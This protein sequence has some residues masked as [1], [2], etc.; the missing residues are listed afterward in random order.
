LEAP[1]YRVSLHSK[2]LSKLSSLLPES[3]PR[4]GHGH[5]LLLYLNEHRN[6]STEKLLMNKPKRK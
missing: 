3:L 1:Q 5:S 2:N 6:V 4:K